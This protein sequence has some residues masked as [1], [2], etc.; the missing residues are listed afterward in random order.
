[1]KITNLKAIKQQRAL[2][3]TKYSF[4]KLLNY[5][6]IEHNATPLLITHNDSQVG[7]FSID[8]IDTDCPSIYK[9]CI[10]TKQHGFYMS[11]SIPTIMRNDLYTN[12]SVWNFL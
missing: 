10:K 12:K 3:A 9:L 5:I 4:T 7:N 11:R 6:E 2:Y 8:S 1:M